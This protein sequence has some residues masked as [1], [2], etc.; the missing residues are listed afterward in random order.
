[1]F[2]PGIE[3]GITT[4]LEVDFTLFPNPTTGGIVVNVSSIDPL[5][6]LTM[7]IYGAEGRLIR[8][9]NYTAT[10][11]N[12]QVQEDVSDLPAGYYFMEMANGSSHMVKP[13]IKQ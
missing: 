11:A 5:K 4:G 3:L 6:G 8:S 12:L 13:L 7:N 1:M 10:A 2:N 9:S